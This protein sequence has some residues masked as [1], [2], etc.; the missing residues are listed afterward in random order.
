MTSDEKESSAEGEFLR[1]CTSLSDSYGRYYGDQHGQNRLDNSSDLSEAACDS[2]RMSLILSPTQ[3]LI[4]DPDAVANGH[5]QT[6]RRG[7]DKGKPWKLLGILFVVF[8]IS[9]AFYAYYS[10][11]H[12]LHE[13]SLL[14]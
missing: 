7:S 1:G 12:I 5:L 8:L 14:E 13:H 2:E 10:V 9:A 3:G 6:L 4:Q 11:S